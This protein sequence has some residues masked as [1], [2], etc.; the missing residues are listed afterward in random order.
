MFWP[1]SI[2][3][4]YVITLRATVHDKIVETKLAF[5]LISYASKILFIVAN[6]FIY[7]TVKR[8]SSSAVIDVP[9]KLNFSL[10]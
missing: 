6:S 2:H 10:L 9:K 7:I 3:G 5:Y 4:K 1:R 8:L